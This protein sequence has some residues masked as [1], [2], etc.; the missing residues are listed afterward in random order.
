MKT[1]KARLEELQMEEAALE[2]SVRDRQRREAKVANALSH[3]ITKYAE[4]EA[5]A[6]VHVKTNANVVKIMKPDES[7]MKIS[8]DLTGDDLIF[9]IDAPSHSSDKRDENGVLDAIIDWLR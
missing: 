6:F 3:D 7:V 8:V 5:H 4:D 1:L 2:A 9:V